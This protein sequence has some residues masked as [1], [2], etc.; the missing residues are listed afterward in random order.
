MQ[1][2]RQEVLQTGAIVPRNTEIPSQRFA[3]PL[4]YMG[5]PPTSAE[6][7][8]QCRSSRA[9]SASLAHA[10]FVLFLPSPISPRG[11]RYSQRLY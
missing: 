10:H 6:P 8:E 11:C 3:L 2:R 1:P 7:D 9:D 4:P 5:G